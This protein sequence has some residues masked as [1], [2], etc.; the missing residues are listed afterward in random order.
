[1]EQKKQAIHTLEVPEVELALGLVLAVAHIPVIIIRLHGHD[2]P[3]STPALT[4][5]WSLRPQNP[6][7]LLEAGVTDSKSAFAL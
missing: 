2:R 4:G 6:Q 1:M 7:K 5:R 3:R